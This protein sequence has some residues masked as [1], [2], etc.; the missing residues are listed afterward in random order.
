MKA[1][2]SQLKPRGDPKEIFVINLIFYLINLTPRKGRLKVPDVS[3]PPFLK[4]GRGDL[5][6]RFE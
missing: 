2:N 4:G 3:N 5:F 6:F 1:Y